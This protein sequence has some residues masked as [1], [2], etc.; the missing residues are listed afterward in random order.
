MG[1]TAFEVAEIRRP[2]TARRNA[3]RVLI[4]AVIGG[5]CVLAGVVGA[6]LIWSVA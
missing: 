2:S 4:G 6:L 5:A 1:L 3:E